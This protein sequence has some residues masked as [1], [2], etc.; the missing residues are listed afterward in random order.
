MT[1]KTRVIT[2]SFAEAFCEV[3]KREFE[4]G[5]KEAILRAIFECARAGIP[6]PDWCRDEFMRAV[7]ETKTGRRPHASWDEVFGRPHRKHTKLAAKSQELK[8]RWKVYY[9]VRNEKA[10]KPHKDPY[11][12]VA[13]RCGIPEST[14]KKYYYNAVK[15]KKKPPAKVFATIKLTPA[16]FVTDFENK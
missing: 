4:T 6:L 15:E 5:D 13:K 9:A 14:C 1:N 16:G 2:A 10:R 7:I 8:L 3:A 12:A 11:P